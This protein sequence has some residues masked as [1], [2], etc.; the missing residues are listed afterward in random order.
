VRGGWE[1][2]RPRNCVRGMY[3]MDPLA[4]PAGSASITQ[5]R[6]AEAIGYS[7]LDRKLWER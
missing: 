5:H 7:A 3:P 2:S 6:V 1:V 4:P